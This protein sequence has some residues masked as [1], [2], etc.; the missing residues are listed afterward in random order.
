MS[1]YHRFGFLFA[2]GLI[3]LMLGCAQTETPGRA[4]VGS[5]LSGQMR[6][7]RD[8][9]STGTDQESWAISSEARSIDR[10][11]GIGS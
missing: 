10:N 9:E 11:L 4:E 6:A 1:N 2:A 3:A 7:I 8:F 5:S